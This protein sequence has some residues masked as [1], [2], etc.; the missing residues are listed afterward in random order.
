MICKDESN[1]T[2]LTNTS[3]AAEIHTSPEEACQAEEKARQE[4]IEDRQ[5]E[6]HVHKEANLVKQEFEK[7][8]KK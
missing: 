1:I 4:R 5:P 7:L 3:T 8:E 6:E 2:D